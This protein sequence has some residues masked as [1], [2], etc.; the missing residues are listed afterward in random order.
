MLLITFCL[1]FQLQLFADLKLDDLV[2]ERKYSSA[3]QYLNTLDPDNSQ[4]ET[5]IQKLD[6]FLNYYVQSISHQ[7]F[8][9]KDLSPAETIDD[10]R[11]KGGTFDIYPFD[12]PEILA[13]FDDEPLVNAALIR[14]YISLHG[15]FFETEKYKAPLDK[16]LALADE[17]EGSL[18]NAAD[19]AYLGLESLKRGDPVKGRYFYEI[20]VSKDPVNPEYNYNLAYAL[21][22]RESYQQA[23][24]Y[25]E[26]A[27]QYYKEEELKN[28]AFM[29]L[30][31]VY[32]KTGAFS[33]AIEIFT[34]LL[35]KQEN[36][37][38]ER[39]LIQALL[40]NGDEVQ[41]REKTGD[42]LKKIGPQEEPLY[43]LANSFLEVSAVEEF[44]RYSDEL[45]SGDDVPSGQKALIYYYQS[46]L[47]YMEGRTDE[48][49]AVLRKAK[50]ELLNSEKGN[51]S[52]QERIDQM[53]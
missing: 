13:K 45:L 53:L 46:Y 44:I 7:I 39:K 36:L 8:G 17:I 50:T 5:V 29:M 41:A 19:A 2:E 40:E 37:F 21:M 38:I 42:Y 6:I 25:I 20:A 49:H 51:E 14:F 43:N 12:A 4:L 26:A 48:S 35:T 28:D 33:T 3:L 1:C 9:L 16:A 52:L 47:Y 34:E 24:P 11:V 30:G 27:C 32:L 18:I 15:S 23:L 10:L 22:M 31:D